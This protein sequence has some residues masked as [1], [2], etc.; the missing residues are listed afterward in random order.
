MRS[1]LAPVVV[2]L[3]AAAASAQTST[4]VR[5][6]DVEDGFALGHQFEQEGFDVVEGGTLAT[7]V[8]LVVSEASM[9]F[10]LS[11]G[12]EPE[13]LSVGR[14]YYEIQHELWSAEP[15]APPVGYKIYGDI[16]GD[17]LALE[18]AF[19]SIAKMVNVTQTYGAPQTF[20]GRDI[21]ALKI[22][23]NVALDEDE[24]SFLLVSNHHARELNTNVV[25]TE[26][27]DKLCND[28]AS[29]PAI[30][31]I[32]DDNEI[33]IA[34]CWNPDGQVYVFTTNSN[35][36]RNRTV[37]PSCTGVD[38]NRNY[39]AGWGSS[40]GG[41]TGCNDTY[42]GPSNS[43][44]AETQT[45]I[46]FTTAER[47]AK[48]LDFHSFGSETLWEYS[49]PPNGST[50]VTHPWASFFQAEAMDINF[51]GYGT[52]KNRHPSAQG[53][54]Y[55]W[56][57]KLGAYAYL[58][59]ISTSFQ[60]PFAAALAEAQQLFG[61]V[62]FMLERE[63]SFSGHTTDACTGLPI[64]TDIEFVGFSFPLN[65]KL[66]SGGPFGR[67]D[68]IPPA[69]NYDV[70]FS[71]TGYATQV[72]NVTLVD[73]SPVLL[74]IAMVP[75]ASVAS[76]YCTAG[77][78]ASGCTALL[79]AAGAASTT[80]GSGFD[81]SAGTVEGAKDGLFF[82]STNG[83]QANSWGSGTSYQCVVPPVQRTGLQV[84][85][86]TPGACDGSFLMDFN[87]W[88]AANPSKA[89]APG[90]TVNLQLWF[91]DP[92]NTSNQTTSLSDGLEFGVCP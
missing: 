50:C 58:M 91:R 11:Q 59:E 13:I 19:P 76:S 87:A 28:Y 75:D 9:E 70:S 24:P 63:I 33:W 47:F 38:T 83:S 84:G 53:E 48:V 7:S 65:G 27:M 60:P 85:S 29:D 78:T 81:I 25:A 56:Q 51:A 17:M 45:M 88:M 43:S 12:F 90:S 55:E 49:G 68:L 1:L 41:S 46:A 73:G 92:L 69:G 22:S 52:T 86:G 80:A 36:R 23:D 61:S 15:D 66:S 77:S 39:A 5:L 16:L 3:L 6:N 89:P 34:P 21:Y 35:W 20:E 62:Q 32:V 74:D 82:F 37:Y 26:A 54:H 71:A 79:S 40:C 18:T 30:Q 64:A 31:A 57:L 14:P 72:V 67:Y 4:H 10:L 8:E 2:A 44:E 42:R